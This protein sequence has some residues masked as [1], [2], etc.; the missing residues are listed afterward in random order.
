MKLAGR[1]K[2]PEHKTW[3]KRRCRKIKVDEKQMPKHKTWMK[4]RWMKGHLGSG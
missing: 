1:K 3:M 4:S 2:M